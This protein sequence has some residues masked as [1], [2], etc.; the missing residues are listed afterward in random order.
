[1]ARFFI[2][3]GE[4]P[5]GAVPPIWINRRNWDTCVEYGFFSAGQGIRYSKPLYKLNVG[6]RVA[7]Y[8]SGKGYVGVGEVLE[9]ATPIRNFKFNGIHLNELNINPDILNG[10]DQFN[11]EFVNE[12]PLLRKSIFQNAN[13]NKTEVVVGINWIKTV[14]RENA[15]WEKGIKLFAKPHTCCSLENQPETIQFLNRMFSINI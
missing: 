3:I 9:T 15:Y 13:N 4:N 1:M 10:V 8:I 14:K 7:A 11:T 6:D 2:N 5:P 12:I